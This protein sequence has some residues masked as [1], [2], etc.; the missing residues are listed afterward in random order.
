MLAHRLDRVQSLRPELAAAVHPSGFDLLP[1]ALVKLANIETVAVVPAV[2]AVIIGQA[3]GGWVVVAIDGFYYLIRV[4]QM[5][6]FAGRHKEALQLRPSQMPVR[7]SGRVWE[8]LVYVAHDYVARMRAN[9]FLHLSDLP[10]RLAEL[11]SA[12]NTEQRKIGLR[13]K[14]KAVTV[15]VNFRLNRTLGESPEVHVAIS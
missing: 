15:V 3:G 13:H 2:V 1:E 11:V 6:D 8:R 14:S 10:E 12:K 5:N 4:H 7:Q 9:E